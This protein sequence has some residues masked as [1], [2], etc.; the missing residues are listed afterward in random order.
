MHRVKGKLVWE[1]WLLSLPLVCR[2]LLPCLQQV[3]LKALSSRVTLPTSMLLALGRDSGQTWK[4][5]AVALPEASL[6]SS[7]PR[8][9][10][11]GKAQ[12]CA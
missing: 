6:R 5:R 1:A 7:P 2:M 10:S 11:V 4:D 12:E 8:P 9:R 3:A